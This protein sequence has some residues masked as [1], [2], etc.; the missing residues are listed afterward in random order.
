MPFVQEKVH[1][2]D[3]YS[4]KIFIHKCDSYDHTSHT[5]K[6]PAFEYQQMKTLQI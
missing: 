4:A 6:N 3:M 1:I 2:F 5:T